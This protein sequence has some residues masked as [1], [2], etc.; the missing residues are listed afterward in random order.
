[1]GQHDPGNFGNR[2]HL[3][4]ERWRNGGNVHGNNKH[5]H[6][7]DWDHGYLQWNFNLDEYRASIIPDL[8]HRSV[9]ISRP[10]C[11]FRLQLFLYDYHTVA[12]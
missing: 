7:L 2:I 1:M 10:D 11:P 9:S 5:S 8:S 6:A 3:R 12:P 4:Q